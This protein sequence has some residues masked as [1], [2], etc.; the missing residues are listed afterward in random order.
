MFQ[1]DRQSVGRIRKDLQ[2]PLV[3]EFKSGS[4]GDVSRGAARSQ[5]GEPKVRSPVR[6][7]RLSTVKEVHRSARLVRARIQPVP[8]A[9]GA[10]YRVVKVADRLL[11]AVRLVLGL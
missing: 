5:D 7:T 6:A 11:E 4:D 10:V 1:H 8:L 2:D 9:K 3:E